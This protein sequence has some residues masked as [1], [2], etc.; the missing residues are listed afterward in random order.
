VIDGLLRKKPAER[1]TA[2]LA[3]QKLTEIAALPAPAAPRGDDPPREGPAD[4]NTSADLTFPR[5]PQSPSLRDAPTLDPTPPPR[6]PPPAPP[7]SRRGPLVAAGAFLVVVAVVVAIVLAN[8]PQD[9]E[10]TAAP[11]T[12]TTT[13]TT[14]SRIPL[15]RYAEPLG[16]EIG[17]PAD[18]ERTA[19]EDGPVSY[20]IW[21]GE[22]VDPK[23]GAL[24][25]KVQRDTT[26][27]GVPAI[28]YLTEADRALDGDPENLEYRRI[29]LSGHG[30]SA[31]LEYTYV[32]AAESKYYHMRVRAMAPGDVYTL[33]FSTFAS[34]AGTLRDRWQAVEPLIAE[35]SDSFRLTS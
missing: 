32:A 31:D 2:R 3:M 15:E 13:T 1:M 6:V 34:D 5:I 4:D 7:R 28:T 9:K 33:T 29:G 27:A 24:E 22:Q 19:S 18:W 10:D 12:V 14:E 21:A 35:I 17:I 25:V 11:P 26:A 16:F 20:V 8:R 23:V 30:T